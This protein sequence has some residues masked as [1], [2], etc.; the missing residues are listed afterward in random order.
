MRRDIEF[1]ADGVTLR[2]WL[3]K[4]GKGKSPFPTVVMAHG[5]SGVKEMTLDKYA[6][7]FCKAGMAV[8]VY[9]NRCL[10]ASGGRPRQDIDPTMQL[11]DYRSAITF[12]GTQRECDAQRIGVWGTSYTGGAVC[13]VAALDRR[14]RCVV[15]QVPF[16]IG[17]RNIQQF[18]PVGQIP[19]FHAMLDEDRARRVEGKPSAYMKMTSLDPDEPHLF[20]GEQTYNYIHQFLDADPDCTWQNRVTLRS[21]EYML[22]YDVSGYMVRLG[23]TPLLMIVSRFDTTTP[24]DIALDCYAMV[25]G[26]KRLLV[27]DADHYAAYTD[28]FDETSAAAC[29]WFVEHL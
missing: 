21:I 10:G 11:R 7:V 8:L 4:P 25:K 2:G 26:P 9:D 3:Y 28:A 27:I 20:P 12:A 22:E 1:K 29:A 15:S 17:W 16:M 24:T 13:A 19:A 6:E 23:V 5:F 14:V 18:M